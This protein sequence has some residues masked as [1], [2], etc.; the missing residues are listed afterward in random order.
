[1]KFKEWVIFSEMFNSPLPIKWTKKNHRNWEGVFYIQDSIAN[2]E[3]PSFAPKN[4]Q[5]IIKLTAPHALPNPE[6]RSIGKKYIISMINE[7]EMGWEVKFELMVGNKAT[8]DITGTG[9]AALVFS[10]VIDG[11]Q[12]WASAEK[13]DSFALSA[14]EANRQSLYRRMLDKMLPREWEVEDLG[15]TFFVQHKTRKPVYSGFSDSDFD[16]Y[17]EE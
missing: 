1:M 6:K 12:Q 8:Q 10:T 13:P 4:V 14:R 5:S 2:T 17:N 15:T 16:D 3:Q 11:I 7:P 9:N